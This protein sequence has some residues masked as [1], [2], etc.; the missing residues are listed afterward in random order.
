VEVLLSRA[1]RSFAV[2]EHQNAAVLSQNHLLNK[3]LQRQLL[4]NHLSRTEEQL[5]DEVEEVNKELLKPQHQ[6]PKSHNE[7]EKVPEPTATEEETPSVVAN[8][9]DVVELRRPK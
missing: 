5:E 1:R 6:E 9:E 4:I 8:E 7:E 3:S 2:E